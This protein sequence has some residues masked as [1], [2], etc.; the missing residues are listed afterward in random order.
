MNHRRFLPAPASIVASVVACV[1]FALCFTGA[2]RARQTPPQQ[3]AACNLKVGDAP[4]LRGLRLG[5]TLEQLKARFPSMQHAVRQFGR[6][7]ATILNSHPEDASTGLGGVAYLSMEFLD[8]RLTMYALQYDSS[9]EWDSPDQFTARISQ[10]LKLPNLWQ[11]DQENH[12][13]RVLKCEGFV[14]R[15]L[16]NFV[17]VESV[18]DELA[19]RRR[20]EEE[21]EKKRQTF[22]F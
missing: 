10:T 20:V 9:A 15:A 5:M 14:V 21:K 13:F 22:K 4:E 1:A 19:Y 11:T 18:P 7:A 12:A 8:E 6:S 16:P 3:T 2:A 17:R